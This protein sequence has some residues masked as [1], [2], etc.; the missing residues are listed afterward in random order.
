MDLTFLDAPA[1]VPLNNLCL[2][3]IKGEDA[4]HF[5]HS[6][7]TSDI[8]SLK[9][10]HGQPSAWCNPQGRVLFLF[11]IYCLHD[12]DFFIL[13]P[14]DQVD[15]FCKRLQMYVFRSAVTIETDATLIFTGLVGNVSQKQWPLDTIPTEAFS[16]NQIDNQTL[17]SLPSPTKRLLHISSNSLTTDMTESDN[18]SWLC[19]DILSG[20]ANLSET[21]TDK[22]LPQM[23]N[24]DLTGGLSYNKG[25]YPGQ[26]IV[27]RVHHRGKLKRRTYLL[28]TT[29][30]KNISYGPITNIDGEKVGEI[31]NHVKTQQIGTLLLAV[32]IIDDARSEYLALEDG[33]SLTLLELPYQEAIS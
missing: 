21:Q 24:L 25:C 6:Q 3:S 11:Q 4:R 31:L 27:I 23:I 28:Q 12:N 18:T 7:F 32:L 26:E 22:Y 2:V 19:H 15:V 33:T 13:L 9:E 16:F 30:E 8:Q 5:L 17:I 14:S 29:V 1:F 20:H 10:G